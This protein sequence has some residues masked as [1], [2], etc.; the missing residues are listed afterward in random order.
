MDVFKMTAPIEDCTVTSQG[1]FRI[2]VVDD[3]PVH[4][5][6]VREILCAPRYLVSEAQHGQ[7]ALHQ[8]ALHDFDA[9]L[10]DKR[11]PGMDGDRVCHE[12]RHRLKKDLLPIVMVTGSSGIDELTASLRAGANDFIRKPYSPVE[13]RAR[14]DA[15]TQRKRLTDQLESAETLLF[16]LA[17]MVEAKDNDTG[18][19]C[20]RLVH[21]AVA[22]GR[23][24]GLSD[25]ELQALRRG[26]ILHD[27][28]KLAIPDSILLK[29]GPLTASEWIIM[30]Q[31]PV[32]GAQL[33]QGL[34]SMS[35]TLDII[36]YH[37]ERW[38]GSGYPA[39]L[40]G[41]QIPLLARVF[42]LCDIYDALA[43]ARAY[44]TALSLAKIIAI[45]EDEMRKGW[46]D[47]KLTAT[48]IDILRYQPD[49]LQPPAEVEADL[50]NNLYNESC[51]ISE[52][53]PV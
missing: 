19:H 25:P 5:M 37:H 49:I 44:K 48:F 32:I 18:D 1:A 10:L 27:L 22:F 39:G 36:H 6:L 2:L 24:L 46:R 9:V 28:G 30:Q 43:H 47:P 13:L 14:V 26:G 45:F 51:S 8:I 23:V 16:T 17:R 15:A 34:K 53:E 38:D 50:E 41:E 40:A 21:C 29:K 7:E 35:T 31:H 52:A 20:S 4:R 12:V 42:Q 33:C 3:D 11:M